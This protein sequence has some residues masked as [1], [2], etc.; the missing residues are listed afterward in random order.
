MS[1]ESIKRSTKKRRKSEREEK[2]L[3]KRR[4]SGTAEISNNGLCEDLPSSPSITKLE[5]T[6]DST[7]TQKDGGTLPD[8]DAVSKVTVKVSKKRKRTTHDASL[9]EPVKVETDVTEHREPKQNKKRDEFLEENR[10]SY[11]DPAVDESL[12]EQSRRALSYAYERCRGF[13]TWKFNKARQNWLLRHVWSELS[14]Y[15][16]ATSHL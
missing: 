14:R 10:V 15:P 3:K 13:E 16:K 9:D 4:K 12:S 6:R 11:P 1:E 8:R 5:S 2:E 7:I